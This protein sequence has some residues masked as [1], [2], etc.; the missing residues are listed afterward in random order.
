M[1]NLEWPDLKLPPINLWSAP[2]LEHKMKTINVI[3]AVSLDG[4]IGVN[5]DIPW[6]LPEDLKR[7]KRLTLN[8]TVIMG[9][10]TF[11]SLNSKPL[12][13]RA[14]LVISSKPIEVPG[15]RQVNTPEQALELAKTMSNEIFIIGGARIYEYFLP[16]ADKIYLTR[17]NLFVEKN[18]NT[19]P[20]L[21]TVHFPWHSGYF[22]S[23][24][25]KVEVAYPLAD[26]H[27]YITYTKITENDLYE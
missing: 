6:H 5:N 24:N 25:Y 11:E 19:S 22:V 14:N 13:N 7:F 26:T 18:T 17:V 12:P 3:A 21:N 1:R 10:K 8:K 23:S 16:L 9:R 2:L 27:E 20:S 4:I 15:V